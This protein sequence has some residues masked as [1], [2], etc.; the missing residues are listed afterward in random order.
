MKQLIVNADDFG[1]HTEIN[2]GIIKGY[3]EGFITSTS[4][5]CSAPCFEEA[6]DL[7]RS[8][9]KLGIGIHLT[10]VG[11]VRSVLPSQQVSTLVD[12]QGNFYSNYVAFS[13]LYYSGRIKHSELEKELRAQIEAGLASGLNITHLDSHQHTHV[14][15]GIAGLV[16]KLGKE[17]GILKI[18][19]PSEAYTFSGGFTTGIGRHI[20]RAGLTFCAHLAE[21]SAK[22]IG[23]K[24]PRHFFGMLAGGNLNEVLVGNILLA[25]PEGTSEIMT[26]PGLSNEKLGKLFKWNYHWEQELRAYLSP[27]NQ[28]L[29]S[30]NKIKIINFGDL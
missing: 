24:Y 10:L 6:V 25:L 30:E 9:P 7:A 11:G 21:Q 18:R 14:L 17:Y 29:L 12:G 1:L 19:I 23:F 16:Q 15:P 22:T 20:G 13:K 4:L 27:I 2:K 8:Y 3:K 26:H 5:M 28:E